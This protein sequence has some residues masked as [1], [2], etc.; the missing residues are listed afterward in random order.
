MKHYMMMCAGF[1][2]ILVS[3]I[4][5]S[6]IDGKWKGTFQGPNGDLDFFY[7][8]KVV[9][10]SLTGNIE[11]QMGTRDFFNG[12]VNKNIFSFDTEWNGTTIYH[13]CT[14]EGDS[15]IMKMPGMGGGEERQLILKR[16]EK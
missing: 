14:L 9:D 1:I 15:V 16:V 3:F 12:K 2:G 11:S 8:F 13:N 10:D 4:A 7:N 6:E 5:A